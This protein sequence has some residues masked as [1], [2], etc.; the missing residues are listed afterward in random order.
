MNTQEMAELFEKHNEAF[1]KFDEIVE[2]RSNRP[3]LHAFLLLEAVC[4][5]DRDMICAA[6]HDQIYLEV[7]GRKFA[8]NCTEEQIIELIRCGVMLDEGEEYFTMFA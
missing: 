5:G 7:D 1:L 6:E 4:P 8:E 3:D 2:K